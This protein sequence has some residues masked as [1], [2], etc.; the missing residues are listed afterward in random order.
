[1]DRHTIT[2]RISDMLTSI[3]T[4][5]SPRTDQSYIV[6]TKP[7]TSMSIEMLPVAPV[8]SKL[9]TIQVHLNKMPSTAT[10]TPVVSS[11][12]TVSQL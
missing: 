9:Q 5:H 11:T 3:T 8:E 6:S 4:S 7:P 12:P 1:M 10:S 2:N